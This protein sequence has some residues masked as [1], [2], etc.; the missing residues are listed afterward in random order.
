MTGTTNIAYIY[1]I[2]SSGPLAVRM[3]V[4]ESTETSALLVTLAIIERLV[5]TFARRRAT[6]APDAE[7]SL[8][9]RWSTR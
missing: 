8:K 5:S 4:N 9:P 3:P 2:V 6:P 7:D 1:F